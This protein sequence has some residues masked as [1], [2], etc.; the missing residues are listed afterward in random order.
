MS[1]SPN[2]KALI[3]LT[4]LRVITLF[5]T[6]WGRERSL[7]VFVLFFPLTL[8]IQIIR[9]VGMPKN[10]GLVTKDLAVD[11]VHDVI[12]GPDTHPAR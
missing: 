5:R 4:T 8:Q 1:V 3:D 9:L 2:K 7:Q 12:V 11:V 10:C 6:G